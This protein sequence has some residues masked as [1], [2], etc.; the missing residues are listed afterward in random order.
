MQLLTVLPFLML[1][2]TAVAQGG[3]SNIIASDQWNGGC[4]DAKCQGHYGAALVENQ[5]C[6]CYVG[7]LIS[8]EGIC[9][10]QGDL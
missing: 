7:L 9:S 6:T 2:T 8:H 5:F 10:C 4:A 3:S 1:A